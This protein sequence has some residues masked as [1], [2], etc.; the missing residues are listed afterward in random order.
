MQG[1]QHGSPA[2]GT[3]TPSC[4]RDT[5]ATVVG[6]WD[7]WARWPRRPGWDRF[8]REGGT[9]TTRS[10]TSGDKTGERGWKGGQSEPA[11]IKNGGV[12]STQGRAGRKDGGWSGSV[13]WQSTG[14]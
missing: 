8:P 7:P 13:T 1:G 5:K 11:E 6:Q 14:L 10:V 3:Q 2:G 12:V 4:R 9:R